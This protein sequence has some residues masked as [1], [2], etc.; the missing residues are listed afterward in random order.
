MATLCSVKQSQLDGLG[1]LGDRPQNGP[2]LSRLVLGVG[3]SIPGLFS[4][5]LRR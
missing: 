4:G 2:E 5:P 3:F 1:D